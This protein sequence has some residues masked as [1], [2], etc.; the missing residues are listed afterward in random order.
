MTEVGMQG[1][2]DLAPDELLN[3][4]E[5]VG[6]RCNGVFIPLNSYE[7]RVYRIDLVEPLQLAVSVQG[8]EVESVV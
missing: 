8:G 5:S 7:N 1:F 2:D 4:I 3:A 6:V